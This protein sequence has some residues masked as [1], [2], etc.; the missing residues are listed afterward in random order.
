MATVKSLKNTELF[1]EITNQPNPYIRDTTEIIFGVFSMHFPYTLDGTFI[2][3][4]LHFSCCI[5][6]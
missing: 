3:G 2:E 6:L 5:L 4:F 1:Q